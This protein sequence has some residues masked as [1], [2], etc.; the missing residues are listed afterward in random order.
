MSNDKEIEFVNSYLAWKREK[1]MYPPRW[2]PEE[3]VNEISQADARVRLELISDYILS[4]DGPAL[5][6]AEANRRIDQIDD[7]VFLSLDQVM[8]DDE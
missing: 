6:V 4:L 3:Y 5:N 2:T 7:M 8:S 1:E